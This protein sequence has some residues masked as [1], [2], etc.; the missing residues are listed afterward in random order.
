MKV[1]GVTGWKDAGKTTLI[2][3]LVS[4]LTERGYSI[5]TVKHAHHAADVDHPGRDSHRHRHAGAGEVLLS[6]PTRWALM[7]ELRGAPEPALPELLAR[8]SPADLVLV[9]GFKR[10]PHPKI[11]CRR[12]DA[13][14][15]EPLTLADANIAAIATDTGKVA[16]GTNPNSVPVF[17]IDGVAAI[18][19]FILAYCRL[20]ASGQSA[21][22]G[23]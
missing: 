23:A 5:S 12:S 18:C 14:K 21:K 16:Q 10:E 13:R 6:S 7:H 2:E 17:Q 11:E 4:E 15:S 3:R 20:Q 9:E 1:Y 22:V 8:L 19:D